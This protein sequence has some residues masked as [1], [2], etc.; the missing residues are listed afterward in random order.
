MAYLVRRGLRSRIG[1]WVRACGKIAGRST[2]QAVGRGSDKFGV[3][4]GSGGKPR[5]AWI[6][7]GRRVTNKWQNVVGM[8]C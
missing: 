1:G 2:M 4:V 6:T 7:G 8:K 3:A 5:V